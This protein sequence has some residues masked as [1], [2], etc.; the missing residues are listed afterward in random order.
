MDYHTLKRDY[1]NGARHIGRAVQDHQFPRLSET[2]RKRLN[3]K[4]FMTDDKWQM[5]LLAGG[6]LLV[7]VSYS[8]FLNKPLYGVT[9]FCVGELAADA[10]EWDHALSSCYDNLPDL[11]GRL[12]EL[13]VGGRGRLAALAAKAA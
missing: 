9:V 11:L 5:R 10:P 12:C 4:N 7:E 1:L 8:W 2:Q 13:D 6:A 3:G